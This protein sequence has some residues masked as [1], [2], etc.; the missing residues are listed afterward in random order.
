MM[1]SYWFGIVALLAAYGSPAV[2]QTSW[3]ARVIV[4]TF[5]VGSPV[6]DEFAGH[7]AQYVGTLPSAS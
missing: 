2:A 3:L 1:N 4:P 6:G 7:K 5:K